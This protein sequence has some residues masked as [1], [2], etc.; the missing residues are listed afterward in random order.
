MSRE[1]RFQKKKCLGIHATQK[2]NVQTNVQGNALPKKEMSRVTRY[3]KKK[4]LGLRATN[5]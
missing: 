2:R 3:Q 5:N 1:T 4:C